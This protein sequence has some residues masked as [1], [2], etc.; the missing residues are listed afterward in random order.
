MEWLYYQAGAVSDP[1][2]IV[3]L[4][5]TSGTAGAFFYQVD[6][7]GSKGYRVITAQYPHYSTVEDWVKGFDHFLDMVKVRAGHIFGAGLGGFL[8]QHFAAK[9]PHRVRS[10][11]L[12]N[13][14]AS[15]RFFADNA[16]T[17]ASMAY[18]T[19]TP[20]LRKMVLDSFPQEGYMELAEKQAI[21]WVAMAVSEEL[22][23][24]DLAGRLSLNCTASTVE[25]LR[26]DQARITLVESNGD[27]MVPEDVRR[28]LRRRY[29]EA[30]VS[31]LKAAGDFPY[32]SSASEVTLFVEVHM[33]GV[34]VFT[35]EAAP[36]AVAA[37]REELRR[38]EEGDSGAT[39]AAQLLAGAEAHRAY[40]AS[41]AAAPPARFEAPPPAP[42]PRQER[43]KWKNPF[44]DD[45]LL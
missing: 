19:P 45:D 44:E 21:D 9:K 25:D 1:N 37:A 39:A 28:D 18:L 29:P 11:L 7:L 2:P 8:A 23:G 35:A 38:R 6:K 20:L 26:L 40:T 31:Q 3:F 13:A 30:R 16:G 24:D 12:C 43:P 36:P 10:L 27:T 33:R 14:F 15:T 4:H 34:G 17:M 42:P 22:S 5:G 32:L 41:A